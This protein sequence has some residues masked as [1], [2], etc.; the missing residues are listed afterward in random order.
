M[1]EILAVGAGPPDPV[2]GAVTLH[3]QPGF[4]IR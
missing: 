3:N 1:G 4:S 2:S